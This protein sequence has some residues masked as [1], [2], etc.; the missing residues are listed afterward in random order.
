MAAFQC[1]AWVGLGF[2]FPL[3]EHDPIGPSGHST[4]ATY[5][6]SVDH[7]ERKVFFPSVASTRCTTLFFHLNLIVFFGVPYFF[8]N[9]VP[10]RTSGDCIASA[11]NLSP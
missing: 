5:K 11:K 1:E 8:Q 7:E 9:H 2:R 10:F 3:K 6:R 4:S